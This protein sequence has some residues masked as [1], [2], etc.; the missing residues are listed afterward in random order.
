MT[1]V[2]LHT[3]PNGTI[4]VRLTSR[5]D[6]GHEIRISEADLAE[7]GQAGL[8][9]AITGMLIGGEGI[10]AENLGTPE[11][12]RYRQRWVIPVVSGQSKHEHDSHDSQV[13]IGGME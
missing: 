13:A 5:M 3:F 2:N 12:Q 8:V 7:L 9:A 1:R 6:G 10:T 4:R 11:Y